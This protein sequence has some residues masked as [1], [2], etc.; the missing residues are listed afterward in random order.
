MGKL[1]NFFLI[2]IFFSIS[3]EAKS[4]NCSDF[5]KYKNTDNCYWLKKV[6]GIRTPIMIASGTLIDE[7]YIVTNKH[8]VEDHPHVIVRFYNGDIRKAFPLSNNYPVDL[9]VLTL[10]K[11]KKLKNI[12]VKIKSNLSKHL[13]VIGFDQGRKKSRIYNEGKVIHFPNLD[14]HPSSRIHSNAESLPG[15]SGGAVIDENYN[16]VGFL[17]S[18]DGNYNEIVPIESLQHVIK[19]SNI[20]LTQEFL[21]QGKNIRICADTLEFAY[22]FQ[23]KPPENL[24]NKIHTICNLSNNKQLFDNVGQT[25]GRW[26]LFEKSIFFLNKSLKLDPYSPNTL[27]SKAISLHIK[28]DIKSE[29]PI[30]LKLL[31]IIPE[32]P[33]VLRLGVQVAGYLRDK[34]LGNR[35]LDLMKKYNPAALPLANDYLQNAFK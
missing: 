25:F 20:K 13:K 7:N 18:G 28:R 6:V 12:N 1:V 16:L 29:K 10:D 22:K 33:Q 34:N 2:L 15:N 17:A 19:E 31:D 4:E 27:L 14:Q 30:I 24:I 3:L 26:G 32:D 23:R 8:V 21:Q 11:S 5:K 35:V 9:V